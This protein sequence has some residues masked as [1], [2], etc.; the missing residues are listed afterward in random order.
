MG[1]YGVRRTLSVMIRLCRCAVANCEIVRMMTSATSLWPDEPSMLYPLND[2]GRTY[3]YVGRCVQM[4]RCKRGCE[5]TSLKT[6]H[7]I[8]NSL[9]CEM[10][11]NLLLNAQ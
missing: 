4:I 10:R 9:E 1:P 7:S 2:F 11:F 3:V 5:G 8:R 6:N